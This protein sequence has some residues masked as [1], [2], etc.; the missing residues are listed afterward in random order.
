MRT[1]TFTP[2]GPYLDDRR[3]PLALKSTEQALGLIHDGVR[4]EVTGRLYDND[5]FSPE[6]RREIEKTAVLQARYAR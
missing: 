1:I 6:Q 2:D 5:P 3:W 4:V